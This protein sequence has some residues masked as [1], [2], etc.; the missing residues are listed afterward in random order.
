MK[1]QPKTVYAIDREK[2]IRC[3]LC[4]NDCPAHCIKEEEQGL[5]IINDFCIECGHCGAIC[6]RGAVNCNGKEL[7]FPEK[8]NFDPEQIFTLI[9]GKR[10]VRS[11]KEK[12]IPQEIMDRIVEVGALTGTA[13]NSRDVRAKVFR[14]DEK[15]QLGKTLCLRILS[16]LKLIN[17]P[18]GRRIM[19][20]KGGGKYADPKLLSAFQKHMAAGAAGEEDPL[21]F[22]APAVMLLTYPKKNK[23]FGR[24]NAVLAG[25]SMMLYA[26]SM[27]IESCMIGFAEVGAQ[28]KKGKAALGIGTDREVGLI[29]TLG[30]GVPQYHRLPHRPSIAME[31]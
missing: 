22:H 16:F 5:S 9:G 4:Q 10:S 12:E 14:G 8:Q 7:P 3:G 29:F 28:G 27:G 15:K 18:V 30:Y 25:Q 21:F 13:S 1:N 20:W 19:K 23:R 24:T 26:H 31:D 17:N 2:C 6:P 11:Y